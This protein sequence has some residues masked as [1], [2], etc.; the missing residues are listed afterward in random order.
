ME[1]KP[2]LLSP[3]VIACLAVLMWSF[4]FPASKVAQIDYSST[5]IVLLRYLA[6]SAFFLPFLFMGRIAK[7]E[8][9]DF[10]RIALLSLIGVTAYQI[11]FVNGVAQVTPPAAA[12]IISTAPIFVALISYAVHGVKLT[13]RQVKGT[14]L[15]FIGVA[16]ICTSGGADGTLQGFALSL[17][18]TLCIATYFLMQ[19]PLL[20]RY[21]SF[22]LV[23]YNTWIATLSMA[24]FTPA[25]L[26]DFAAAPQTSSTVSVVIMGIFSSGLGFVLWFKAI[27][28][29]NP[30]RIMVFMYLQPVFVGLMAWVWIAEVPSL[31]ACIGGLIVLSVLF[32][33]NR[34]KLPIT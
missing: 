34:Q 19:K 18:A 11:L 33:I 16:L 26:Q 13:K 23:A 2:P 21:S 10:L 8:P 9:R 29:S 15:G 6:A 20:K 28:L 32:Y 17:A 7:V 4:S 25:L 5:S 12:M 22:D 14:G 24:F 31:Q 3:G 1:K 27:A 30:S